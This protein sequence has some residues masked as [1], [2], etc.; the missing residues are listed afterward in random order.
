MTKD[1]FIRRLIDLGFTKHDNDFMKGALVFRQNDKENRF[2][3]FYKGENGAEDTGPVYSGPVYWYED[4]Y[5][6]MT[7]KAMDYY[8]NGLYETI[9]EESDEKIQNS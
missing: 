7:P 1:D 6:N 3:V 9:T 2:E 5:R 8:V 4:L